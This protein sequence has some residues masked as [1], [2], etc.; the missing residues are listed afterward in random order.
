MDIRIL[1]TRPLPIFAILYTYLCFI[2]YPQDA[3][4]RNTTLIRDA[5]IENTIRTYSTPVFK[6]AGLDPRSINI[7]IVNDSSLNAF[8]AGGQNLFIHTGLITRSNTASQI[9]GVIAHETGHIAGGHLSRIKNAL[10][11]SSIPSILSYILGGAATLATGRGDVGAAIVSAGSSIGKRS[12]LSYSRGEEASADHAALKLLDKTRQSAQGFLE[13]MKILE[14]QDL[15]SSKNQDPYVLSHPISSDRVRTIQ[16]HVDQSPNSQVP[17]PAEFIQMHAR[18]KAKLIAFISAPRQTLQIY[19]SSNLSIESRYARTIAYYRKGDI[20]KATSL[21]DHL[22][23]DNPFDPYFI[24][25]RGQI[26]FENGRID[27]ALRDYQKAHD[28]LPY[29][30]VISKE[31]AYAQIESGHTELLKPAI[32]NLRMV[33]VKEP[34]SSDSWHQIAIAYGRIGEKGQS[35]LALAE[36][37]LLNG[38]PDIA[39]YHGRLAEKLFPSGTREWLQAQDIQIFAKDQEKQ[40]KSKK[41]R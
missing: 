41:N 19:K 12:F 4:A 25:L 3:Y 8:V 2:A 31:L 17:T 6:A 34:K 15:F 18:I 9:I 7:Y 13:F 23:S 36:E 29:S 1:S 24:E 16:H 30:A 38:K 28:M 32:K 35:A 37:A 20:K 14:D 5:E 39:K 33:L 40:L 22:I 26:L 11:A 21:L 27:E 10:S